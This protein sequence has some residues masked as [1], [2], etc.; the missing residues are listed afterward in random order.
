MKRFAMFLI[1]MLLV[2]TLLLGCSEKNDSSANRSL[3]IGLM[4]DIGMFPLLV[5]AEEGYFA[6]KELDIELLVFKSAKDRDAALQGN[7]L[8]GTMS[9]LVAVY[10]MNSGGLKVKATSITESRFLLLAGIDSGITKVKDLQD[11]EI[12]LST[13]TVIEYIVD[14]ILE[15]DSVNARK[16]SVPKIPM[17]ME[18]LRNG[19]L[20]SASLP[21]PLA[22]IMIK[23]GAVVLADSSSDLEIDP[24]VMIFTDETIQ[25]QQDE[26]EDF[27]KAYNKAVDEINKNPEN[28]RH[29]LVDKGEFPES[30]IGDIEIPKFRRV[31]LPTKEEVEN[32]LTWIEEK[33]LKK[34]D[35]DYFDLVKTGIF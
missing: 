16:L 26:L 14:L 23:S 18:L 10:F 28:Y 13:N 27:Y 12:G 25:K 24:A 9:D 34:T 35:L 30:V 17:R 2:V 5:A 6:D 8:N 19:Q 32:V 11:V 31:L 29:L 22:T 3:K 1:M 21:D 15:E 20:N 7:Q 4:P 33:G